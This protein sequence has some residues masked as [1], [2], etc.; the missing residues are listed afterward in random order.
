[1][2]VAQGVNYLNEDKSIKS[3]LIT[4]DHKRIGVMYLFGVMFMFLLGVC[5]PFLSVWSC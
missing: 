5:L 1:M 2:S 3:W 4:L